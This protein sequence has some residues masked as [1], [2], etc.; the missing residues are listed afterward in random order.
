MAYTYARRVALAQAKGFAD[1]AGKVDAY[2]S[3]RRVHEFIRDEKHDEFGLQVGIED[4]N[5]DPAVA[6][7]YYQAYKLGDQDDY[8]AVTDK[9]DI[10]IVRY[11]EDGKPHG[12][13]AKLFVDE[14]HYVADVNDWNVRYPTKTRYGHLIPG[15][16]VAKPRKRRPKKGGTRAHHRNINRQMKLPKR[17]K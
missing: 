15:F 14:L 3:Y 10:L 2:R 9:D 5:D 13:K 7:L 11:D 4:A 6:M 16:N 1:P 17:K 8:E 12:A